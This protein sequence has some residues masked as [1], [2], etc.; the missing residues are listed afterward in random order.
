MRSRRRPLPVEELE[1]RRLFALAV[2]PYN[3]VDPL[4]VL[5]NALVLGGSGITVTG[6]SYAGGMGHG[7]TFT[8]LNFTSNGHTVSQDNGVLLTTGLAN[9]ALGPND[10]AG[11]NYAW[12]ATGDADL[13][14][15]VGGADTADANV[16]TINFTVDPGIQ[17]ISFDLV[18]GSDEFPEY[19]APND[20]FGAFLDGVHITAD[21]S[22][23]PVTV[24]NDYFLLN[25][26]GA[27]LTGKHPVTMSVEYDGLTRSLH[28]V[29]PLDPI[30]TTH[31]LKFAIA[32][33]ID[34]TIDSGVFLSRLAGSSAAAAGAPATT[35]PDAPTG[36]SFDFLTDG[37]AV[38]NANGTVSVTIVRGGN[39]TGNASI[40]FFTTDGTAVAGTDYTA[41][42]NG[43]TFAMGETLKTFQF[44]IA[45]RPSAPAV[46]QFTITLFAPSAGAYLGTTTTH[47][48]SLQNDRAPVEIASAT[49][50]A[51]TNDASVDITVTRTGNT[52]IPVTVAYSTANGTATADE[53][54]TAAMGTLSF[55]AGQTTKTINVP[56][57]GNRHA[58]DGV[59]FTLDL[60]SP[61]D[62]AVLLGTTSTAVT[63][64]NAY[65]PV[66]FDLA[67]YTATTDDVSVTL[68]VT[69]NGN[70]AVA[71]SIDYAT[72]DGTAATEVDYMAVT[73]TLS[74]TAG[75]TSKSITVPLLGN[76]EAS[77][78]RAF[79]VQLSN[80]AGAAVA[81]MV[82][83]ATV[84]V[85]NPYSP[86]RLGAA[87]YAVTTNDTTA[88]ISVVRTGNISLPASVDFETT[89]LEAVSDT[90]Y[91]TA[92]GIVS[93]A[94]G[95]A[96][97][98]IS[99]PLLGNHHAANGLRFSVR[100]YGGNGAA[101]VDN[102]WTSIVTIQNTR[103]P[104]QFTGTSY[105]A[106][107][108][109]PN[110][111]LTVE[112][113]GNT[114]VGVTVL[115]AT[116]N[117]SA[118]AGTD[119][120][121]VSGTLT[122]L[123]SETSK[124]ITVPLRGNVA[125]ADGAGF[126]VTLSSP[127]GGGELA[128]P[129]SA[130]VSIANAYSEVR[131]AAATYAAT[132]QS[133]QVTL[134]V[135][136][137]G[138]TSLAGSV[139]YATADGTGAAGVDYV[140]DSG[141][142]SFAAGESS[143]TVTVTLL[144]DATSAASA[145][146]TLALSAN[147]AST[148]VGALD[149]AT[150][151][152]TNAQSVVQF[153]PATYAIS[154]E[155]GLVTLA[156]TRV[157]N[158]SVPVTVGYA[159][160][161]GTAHAGADYSAGAGTVSLAAGESSKTFTVPVLPN[162]S[163]AA[164]STFTVDLSGPAGGAVVG[165]AAQAVVTVQ[166]L[167][168][169]V[170]FEVASATAARHAGPAVLVVRRTGNLSA[171]ATVSFGTANGTASAGTDFVA[172]TGVLSFAAGEATKTIPI[173]LI[174]NPLAPAARTLGVSLSGTG[175][176]GALGGI[177]AMTVTVANTQSVVQFAA[178][179]YAVAENGVAVTVTLTRAGNI[180]VP[181]GVTFAVSGGTATAGL[182][183]AAVTGTAAF[184]A[185]QAAI[186]FDVAVH[187]DLVV[188]PDETIVLSLDGDASVVAGAQASATLTV[189]D[190]T[191][192]PKMT[193]SAIVPTVRGLI[194]GITLTFDQTLEAAPPVGAFTLYTRSADKPGVAPR[195][196]PVAL[197]G[198][199]YDAAARAVTVRPVRPLKSGAFYQLVVSAGGVRNAAGRPLDGAG[200]GQEGTPL[201]LVFSQGRK[202]KYVDHNRDTVQLKVQG[203]GV[204]QL[205]R[206][207]DGEA[208][209]LTVLG[210]TPTTKLSG[211]VARSRAG[212][213][214]RTSIAT[215][216]GLGAATNL[217]NLAQFDVGV[218]T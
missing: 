52:T 89:D 150:V 121:A 157:G 66:Q 205:V 186:S 107:T 185:G 204:L 32:D 70:T 159:T 60:S 172:A 30:V 81:G 72:V 58:A 104:L 108:D 176:N 100:I 77:G 213:D 141:V 217:L 192:G 136:R 199:T 128:A 12:A 36:A 91:T 182:D 92:S 124:T 138:N 5:T 71:A 44:T 214:G 39:T 215:V 96:S 37:T 148:L 126:T 61:A 171:A 46:S 95:E 133:G 119:F 42:T 35:D 49:Y 210:A 110:V 21:G 191:P 202:L 38:S 48:V 193:T 22:G 164:S 75:Q 152:A 28:V 9:N 3:P 45:D 59:Q 97:K 155:L 153:A 88:T 86:V 8:G 120:D 211:V 117:G 83:A 163:A 84:T 208:L 135:T 26:S 65:A 198:A 4:A 122:F 64:A 183:Y 57:L 170:Q 105:P 209:R 102:P 156:V 2:T 106:T 181:L 63:I 174:A 139:A 147:D 19:V 166:N 196:K 112:R 40:N 123:A 194:E 85:L 16:L 62:G 145:T 17:S 200:N 190:T 87:G 76:I 161:D 134:T 90:D 165:A 51:T 143:R 188:D 207:F 168:S 67:A 29:A 113:T 53:D 73:G 175:G 151:T 27:A 10:S 160:A 68:F 118:L 203:P 184:A 177:S 13:E 149:Q 130:T 131:L 99:V 201:V 7:G 94:A 20:T 140:A 162:A 98:T 109:D 15:L 132:V 206:R 142:L 116:S 78:N 137:A 33:V 41:Q 54:F 195:L 154:N 129:S 34:D 1:A 31:T 14:A 50:A 115:Y 93:F 218:I 158:T 23:N 127:T 173:T 146:F 189:A 79:T 56:L 74:F 167:R 212:G 187:P 11:I 216:A 180:D 144:G 6:S 47:T 18:F 82:T 69:R 169:L 24:S 125:G 179:T 55:L 25:N 103:A 114:A 43:Y 101:V 178:A 80:P 111:T 197:S